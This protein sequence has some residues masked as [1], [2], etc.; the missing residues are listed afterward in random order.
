MS[1]GPGRAWLFPSPRQTLPLHLDLCTILSRRVKSRAGFEASS[2]ADS[3]DLQRLRPALQ[4][5]ALPTPPAVLR[6]ARPPPGYRSSSLGALRLFLP[7][8]PSVR[9]RVC[10]RMAGRVGAGAADTPCV[11]ATPSAM[12]WTSPVP[13]ASSFVFPLPSAHVAPRI[14]LTVF[15]RRSCTMRPV[16]PCRAP[17][18]PPPTRPPLRTRFTFPPRSPDPVGAVRGAAHRRAR[19]APR[20]SAAGQRGPSRHPCTVRMLAAHLGG[21]GAIESRSLWHPF[22][23]Q[24]PFSPRSRRIGVCSRRACRA[25]GRR[26][27][28][29]RP[30]YMRIPPL[31]SRSRTRVCGTVNAG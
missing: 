4:P 10:S 22:S 6:R 27:F 24:V 5:P 8:L 23:A 19:S 25:P 18:P 28:R 2:S 29:P 17:L 14:V 13:G 7:R 26:P 9:V 16:L 3:N 20:T 15:T 1:R 11:R 21:V 31:E 12:T 30:A